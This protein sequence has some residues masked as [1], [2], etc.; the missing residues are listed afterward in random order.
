MKQVWKRIQQH[1][2][3]DPRVLSVNYSYHVSKMKKEKYAAVVAT[4][5][6]DSYMAQECKITYLKERLQQDQM[7]FGLPTSS[8]L[9]P[10]LERVYVSPLCL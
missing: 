10:E 3:T 8:P 4:V 6:S 7:A 5:I 2:V 9:K 1:H